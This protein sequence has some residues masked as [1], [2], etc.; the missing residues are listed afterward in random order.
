[1]AED[2]AL[3]PMGFPARL[4]GMFTSPSTVFQEVKRRPTWLVPLLTLTLAITAMWTLVMLS[5]T[6]QAAFREQFQERAQNLP[7]E[8]L[9]KQLAVMKFG[10]PIATFFV[11][12]IFTLLLAGLVYL[13]FSIILGGEGTFR[14]TFSAQ[15]HS[16][17]VG[18]LGG[19]VG[20]ALIFAKG[21]L[22]SSTA[23]SAFLPFLEET[24]LLYKIWRS[25]D[26]FL[27]W[28]LALLSIGM[29]VIQGTGTRKS[30]TVIFSVF[31]VAVV[32]IAVI[33][34]SMA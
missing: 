7:P 1:M 30:A 32:I 8:V 27:I 33:R 22:K 23:L 20:T 12:P 17:L 2:Q 18:L 21:N 3:S 25:F 9:E 13:I 28:Q 31:V 5:P 14:Q 11:T 16:G 6:G 26:I 34:Q 19:L 24:S 4:A 29:G 10:I 15:V